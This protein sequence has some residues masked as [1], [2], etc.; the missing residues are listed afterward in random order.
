MSTT[1]TQQQQQ[2]L[3]PDT[4]AIIASIQE[5]D[6]S[7]SEEL[8]Q[9]EKDMKKQTLT[10]IMSA[11]G[12]IGAFVWRDVIEQIMKDAMKV[13]HPTLKTKLYTAII[14][15]VICVGLTYLIMKK[16]KDT[17]TQTVINKKIYG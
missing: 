3:D 5:G 10:F 9:I 15:T 13:Q 6:R 7:M 1:T 14:F 12:L 2:K 8:D 16:Y 17:E 11:L 4:K